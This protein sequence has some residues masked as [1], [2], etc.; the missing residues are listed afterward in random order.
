MDNLQNVRGFEFSKEIRLVERFINLRKRTEYLCQALSFED[1]NLSV[2]S[3]TSPPKW[4]L[5]HTTWF[6]ERFVLEKFR[7]DYQI[8]RSEYY[9]LFNS[10]YRSSGSFLKKERRN[11]L[12][13]PGVEEIYLYREAITEQIVDLIQ[14]ISLDQKEDFFKVLEIGIQH[15]QQHQE[16]LLMDI[17]RNFYENPLRPPYQQNVTFSGELTEHHWKDFPAGLVKVGVSAN[18]ENFAFDNEKDQHSVWLES[19]SLASHL[20][21]NDEYLSFMNEGGYDNPQLWLADGWELKEREKLTCPLYWE[22]H[23]NDWWHFTLSGMMPLELAAPVT[24]VNYFEAQA[25][26]RWK[27]AR[28]P[29]EAEWEVAA[30]FEPIAGHFAEVDIYEPNAP[31][32]NQ[33]YFSQIHG[34]VW[35]WTQSSY[36][37]Y[38]R[39]HPLQHGLDEYNGKFMCNQFVLRG[40]SCV[41]P[42]EHYRTSYRNFYYPHMRWQF[43]GIRLARDH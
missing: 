25:F 22:K 29:R 3:E 16:L 34:T 33:E 19:F 30:R 27:K 20:V 41:T 9:F 42:K 15:E 21:S 35:E 39:F 24:H 4:H 11:V 7:L 2:T 8:Y 37:P 32:E 13:R 10:Y 12:S 17:K 5:A 23:G 14:E 1:Y 40:G 31:E 6:F 38:P 36:L 28:L 26:A 43:S 18:S